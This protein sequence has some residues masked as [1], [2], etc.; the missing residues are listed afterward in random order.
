MQPIT[1]ESIQAEVSGYFRLTT[2]DLL[3]HSRSRSRARARQFAMALSRELTGHSL[4]ELGRLFQRD[5]TTVLHGVQVIERLKRREG[6]FREDWDNL[7][8]MLT[9]RAPR[10]PTAF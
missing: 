10:S 5:H 2:G 4:P 9:R 7:Y 3:Q 1:V 6:R 8:R